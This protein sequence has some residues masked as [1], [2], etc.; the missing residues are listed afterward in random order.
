MLTKPQSLVSKIESGERKL[1]PVELARLGELYGRE[2]GWF[3]QMK[4]G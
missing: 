1:D 3:L 4:Q 2:V